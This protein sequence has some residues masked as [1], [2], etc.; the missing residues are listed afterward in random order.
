[1]ESSYGGEKLRWRAV[2][3]ESSMGRVVRSVD[4]IIYIRLLVVV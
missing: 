3:V 4:I 1:V 2:M